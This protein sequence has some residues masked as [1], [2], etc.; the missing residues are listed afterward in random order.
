MRKVEHI[1]LDECLLDL[2]VCPIDE[3]L[4]IE[5]CLLGKTS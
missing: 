3:E 4:V 1:L 2:F 5:I